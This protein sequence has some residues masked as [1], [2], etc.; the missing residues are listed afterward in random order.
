VNSFI[1]RPLTAALAA[2]AAIGSI[3]LVLVES[4]CDAPRRIVPGTN[5]IVIPGSGQV[6]GTID[7]S[8]VDWLSRFVDGESSTAGR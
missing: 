5:V 3:V 1:R 8:R 2:V 7:A 6:T 4:S